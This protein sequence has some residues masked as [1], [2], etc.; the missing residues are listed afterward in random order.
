MSNRKLKI[1]LV[2]DTDLT[3]QL[4][5][6][7]KPPLLK[8]ESAFFDF[9]KE[10]RYGF[11]NKNVSFPISLIFVDKDMTVQDIKELKPNQTDP[12][13]PCGNNVRYVIE[14][15]IDV[16]NSLKI[17]KGSKIKKDKNWIYFE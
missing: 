5:L 15:H 14:S 13:Q 2:A 8:S 16:P 1:I 7:H 12:V 17:R 11:W 10:G 9:K 3:R 6:M 4:G